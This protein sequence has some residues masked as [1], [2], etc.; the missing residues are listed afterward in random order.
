MLES[1]RGELSERDYRIVRLRSGIDGAPLT[2]AEIAIDT[3]LTRQRI[4]A[5]LARIERDADNWHELVE[6]FP[7]LSGR[8]PTATQLRRKVVALRRACK[9]AKAKTV[10]Q[11]SVLHAAVGLPIPEHRT[12]TAGLMD[13]QQTIL[14]LYEDYGISRFG[15][16]WKICGVC[17]AIRKPSEF[18]PKPNGTPGYQC[19]DCNRKRCKTYQRERRLAEK[20]DSFGNSQ[21]NEQSDE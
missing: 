4:Q 5:I 10:L 3:G 2:L 18:Y 17:S 7:P 8:I 19:K 9:T 14:A 12:L 6:A 1:L 20:G 11:Y 13:E 21:R 15:E 16:R